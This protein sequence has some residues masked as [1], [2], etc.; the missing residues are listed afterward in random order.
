MFLTKRHSPEGVLPREYSEKFRK[1]HKKN[2]VPDPFL[3]KLQPAVTLLKV[4]LQ[5]RCFPVN[6]AQTL[7]K[8]FFIEPRAN[9]S[10]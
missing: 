8:L 9:A 1:V 4:E 10:L 6:F 2:S 5:H 3:K 7:R